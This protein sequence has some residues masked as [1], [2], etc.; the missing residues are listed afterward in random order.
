MRCAREACGHWTPDLRFLRPRGVQFA[1]HWYCSLDCVEA[2]ARARLEQAPEPAVVA[3]RDQ[4]AS[5]L[6]ALLRHARLISA[7]D[8]EAA[9]EA[10]QGSGLRLGAQLCRMGA[11]TR[12][13]VLRALATQGRVGYVATVDPAMVRHAPGGLS[14][15]A[16]R[17]L[18]VVPIEADRAR[19]SLKVACAAPLPR[20]ALAVLRELTDH[21][22]EPLLVDDA[23]LLTLIQAYGT[24]GERPQVHVT[25]TDSIGDA[26]HR[27][28]EAIRTGRARRMQPVRCD[29]WL[30]VRL[31]G[32][33]APEEIV[34]PVE[35][36]R[37][38]R[39]LGKERTWR[40]APTAH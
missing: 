28:A 13:D 39:E 9:L 19:R 31:E 15:D 38:G 12:R 36:A 10:Q 20:L 4:K 16:I 17:A 11:V 29:P 2:E 18:G 33:D 23:Q 14:P 32:D 24:D 25:R 21:S 1:D 27:I 26:A 37:A 40:A 35:A 7:A 3:L 30:W 6:G 34:L 5:R 8:L 22:I